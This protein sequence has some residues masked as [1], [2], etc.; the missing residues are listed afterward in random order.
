MPTSSLWVAFCRLRLGR[1]VERLAEEIACSAEQA[2]WRLVHGGA[3]EMRR[4]EARGYIHAKAA[5]VIRAEVAQVVATERHLN[6]QAQAEI[7]ARARA[8]VV[9]AVLHRL[10]DEQALEHVRARRAA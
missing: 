10:L 3:L 9:D 5:A 2:V 1:I 4:A 7:A 8:L 6:A